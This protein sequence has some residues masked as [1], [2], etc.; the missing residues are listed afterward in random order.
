[1]IAQFKA[2]AGEDSGV[3]HLIIA[4][5]GSPVHNLS[6]DG[7]GGQLDSSIPL[8]LDNLLRLEPSHTARSTHDNRTIKC[9]TG[10]TVTELIALQTI[11]CEIVLCLTSSWIKTGETMIRTYP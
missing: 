5:L 11:I 8:V 1:M 3:R 2:V 6:V 10:G 9:H 4:R 7:K